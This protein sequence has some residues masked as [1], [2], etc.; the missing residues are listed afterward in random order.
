MIDLHAHV[1][2]GV[3]DGP[4]DLAAALDLLVAMV[5]QGTRHVVA[6]P[7]SFDDR[8][9]NTGGT[10]QAAVTAL[11]AAAD[12]AGLPIR[13][14][15]GMELPLR[16]DLSALLRSGQALGIAGTRYVCVELP[17]REFPF[18]AERA[19][20][21]L[22]LAGWRPILNHPERNRAI[23]DKPH[24]LERLADRGVLAMVSAGSLLGKFG[25]TA[26]RLA[27]GF[28]ESGAATL[29]VSDA[30]DRERRAPLL[31]EALARAR[32]HGKKSQS[33]EREILANVVA[34]GPQRPGRHN[35]IDQEATN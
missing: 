25:P 19:F 28:L 9:L 15:P 24:L 33:D 3:D 20:Y 4:A 16:S 14:L 5:E 22:M 35:S 29:V 17:H 34:L 27:G 23:Q 11:Q 32:L 6:S 18:Y 12:Q 31:K 1:L 10:V 30:H 2:P 26:E 21:E 7:H 13:I 8:Y